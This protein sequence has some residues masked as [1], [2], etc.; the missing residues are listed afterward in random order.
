MLALQGITMD[1]SD[2]IAYL[3][4]KDL[5]TI[6]CQTSKTVIQ[7]VLNK[8]SKEIRGHI[9]TESICWIHL[10]ENWSSEI[11]RI[12]GIIT[13]FVLNNQKLGVF[14]ISF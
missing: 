2:A 13:F 12:S 14:F 4:E 3:A 1:D 11:N 6:W 7:E 5:T 9:A 10:M 8:L